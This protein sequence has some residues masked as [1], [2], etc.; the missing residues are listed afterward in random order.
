M[1]THAHMYACMWKHETDGKC[2]PQ[3]PSTLLFEA[4]SLSELAVLA[5]LTGQPAHSLVL[6]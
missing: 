6:R 4:G 2:L 1:G 3:S 5:R